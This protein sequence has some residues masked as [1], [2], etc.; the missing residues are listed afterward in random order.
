MAAGSNQR[1]LSVTSAL[2]C[3]PTLIS[4][5]PAQA[6]MVLVT[7]TPSAIPGQVT[8]IEGH[9]WLSRILVAA[10]TFLATSMSL[11]LLPQLLLSKITNATLV[12]LPI[13]VRLPGLCRHLIPKLSSSRKSFVYQAAQTI[14]F[15]SGMG[16]IRP[17][18]G[19]I[20]RTTLS[21]NQTPTLSGMQR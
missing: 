20:Y 10:L 16:F 9:R 2:P 4:R 7:G 17:N 1:A 14:S 19:L 13:W 6:A 15:C 18:S 3:Q 11:R 5:G 21:P 12:R 8:T